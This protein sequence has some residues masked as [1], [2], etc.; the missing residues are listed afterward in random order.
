MA[1][2]KIFTTDKTLN[3]VQDE[4]ARE[5]DNLSFLNFFSSGKLLEDVTVG[6]S[7]T[8]IVHGLGQP[9]RGWFAVRQ[10]TNAVIW[11]PS[12]TSTPNQSLNLQATSSCTVS[13]IIF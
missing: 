9:V 11:E 10:D 4:V 12:T 1:F 13:L 5:L 8:E 2:K 6:T 3:R 7:A